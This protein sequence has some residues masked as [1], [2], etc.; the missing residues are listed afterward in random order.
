MDRC[1]ACEHFHC[2]ICYNQCEDD[3][4]TITCEVCGR[5]ITIEEF[6]KLEFKSISVEEM[7]GLFE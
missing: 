5:S 6:R 4:I 3:G 1:T 7:F 2:D